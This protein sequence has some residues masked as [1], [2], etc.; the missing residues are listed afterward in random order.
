MANYWRHVN[1]VLEDADLILMVVDARMIE[2]TR[3][4]ELEKKIINLNKNLLY[5]ITKCDL[6]PLN[7][8][9]EKAKDLKPSVFISSIERLGTTILKRKILEISHGKAVTVGIV[10]YPNVGKSSLINALSGRG[11]A[12][13][14]T[15][16]GFTKGMQKVR[17]DSKIILI[18]TPGVFPNKQ[19]DESKYARTGAIDYAKLKEPEIPALE[20][21]KEHLEM[22]LKQYDITGKNPEKILERIARKIHKLGRGGEPDLEAT[23]RFILR[24]WQTGKMKQT[25][26]NHNNPS[27]KA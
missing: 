15:E 3:N 2:E 27:K 19:K 13:T 18:D 4:E 10:G 1:K 22:I 23:A 8:V 12:R 11:S 5:V 25:P 9:K 7:E 26:A 6:L 17:V 20:L 21:I 16:S 24:Q 14:S